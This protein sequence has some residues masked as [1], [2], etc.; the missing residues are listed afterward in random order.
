M[1]IYKV[2]LDLSLVIASLTKF[3][4]HEYN[5]AFPI[6]FVEANDPDEAC[7]IATSGLRKTVLNQDSS[8]ETRIFCR[9]IRHDIKV[10]RAICQ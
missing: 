3:R 8:I 2:Y 9:E 4:L 1:K 7:I 6:I 5:S 10:L